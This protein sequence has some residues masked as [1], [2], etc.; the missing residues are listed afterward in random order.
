MVQEDS[1]VRIT[2]V[3]DALDIAYLLENRT[4]HTSAVFYP[5]DALC[6]ASV[7]IGHFLNLT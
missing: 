2:A 5:A 6:N 4:P 7:G 3:L 1:I